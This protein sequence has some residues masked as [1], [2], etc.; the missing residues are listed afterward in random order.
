MQTNVLLFTA[1]EEYTCRW[2]N[3]LWKA[4]YTGWKIDEGT[5]DDCKDPKAKGGQCVALLK[6]KCGMPWTGCWQAGRK[7]S[8]VLNKHIHIQ[9]R[10]VRIQGN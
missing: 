4:L 9:S 2:Y 1:A 5:S 3:W 8:L 10:P 7:V 6:C